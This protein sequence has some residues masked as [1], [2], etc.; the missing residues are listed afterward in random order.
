MVC[1]KS[2]GWHWRDAANWNYCIKMTFA[3]RE[4][5]K[6]LFHSVVA[7]VRVIHHNVEHYI[8][9]NGESIIDGYETKRDT[10][11]AYCS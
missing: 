8:S 10:H 3:A 4:E 1:S 2:K 9:R 6:Q 7:N 11:M 5:R